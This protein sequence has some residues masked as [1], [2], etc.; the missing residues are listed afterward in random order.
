MNISSL[1]IPGCSFQGSGHL[2]F[3]WPPG[4]RQKLGL[5]VGFVEELPTGGREEQAAGCQEEGMTGDQV[6]RLVKK[7]AG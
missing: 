3:R 5:L 4:G 6:V 1:Q 7:G 2:P